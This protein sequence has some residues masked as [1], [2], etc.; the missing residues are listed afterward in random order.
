MAVENFVLELP[1]KV[2]KWQ[3]DILNKRY[4]Y[5]RQIYNYVQQKLIRQYRYFEQMKEYRKCK[6]TTDKRIFFQN[7][8]FQYKDVLGRNGEPI[9]IRFP[10]SKSKSS[11]AKLDG[12]NGYITKLCKIKVGSG[13]TYSDLG[14]NSFMLERLAS[15]LWSSWDKFLYDNKSHRVSF[16][17]YEELNSF[18]SR[19]KNNESFIG[20]EFHL[21]TMKLDIKVN[22]CQGK[23]AK[24]ITL[25][26][27]CK[28]EMTEYELYA[29]KGGFDSIKILNVVR[30]RIRGNFKYYI[31]MT[32]EG[33]KPQKGRTLGTGQVGVDLGPSTIAVSSKGK[34]FIDKLAD[35]CDNIQKK[36]N[37]VSRK[38]DRSRR[39]NNPQNFNEDG[40]IKPVSHKSGERRKWNESKRYKSL[41]DERRELLR[42]QAAIRKIQ[43]IETANNLLSLGDTFVVENNPISSWA[44][45]SKETKINKKGKIQSKK[46]FGKSVANHA[47]AMF[48]TILENKV[49]SLGGRLEKVDVKNAAS[50]FDFTNGEFTEHALSER[51]IT[52]SNGNKHQRDML[53]AFNLQHLNIKGDLTKDYNVKDMIEDYP[54]FCK[55]ESKEL[56]LYIK[57]EKKNERTSIGAFK[58]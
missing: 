38:M 34:V 12:F 50:R 8:P 36:L 23:Q 29:L 30:K 54:T 6:T 57:G 25:P 52:L 26:V 33:E 18:G 19:K 51:A 14:I 3:A 11:G 56:D 10:H 5:L 43:H 45:K 55:L 13:Y 44:K 31:Q 7:H 15:N 53:S 28:K 41:K 39:A 16:K 27:D 4:E 58:N 32:I 37:V 2:E 21:D 40:T 1:L 47:P 35:K 22:G 49:K 48:V 17:K 46:R 24:R 20:M 42:K 9:E